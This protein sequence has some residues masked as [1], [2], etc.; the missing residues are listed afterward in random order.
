MSKKVLIF[1]PTEGVSHWAPTM[2]AQTKTYYGRNGKNNS[3]VS[4]IPS[5]ADIWKG[6]PREAK[7]FIRAH[8]PDIFGVSLYLWNEVFGHE[9]AKWVKEEF[10]DCLV[11]S[12]GPHQ[13]FKYT[14]DWYQKHPYIDVSLPGDSYG[15]DCMTKII[16]EEPYENIADIIWNDKGKIIKSPAGL[17]RNKFDYDWAPYTAQFD[18]IMQYWEYAYRYAPEKYVSFNFETTRGCP[19]GCTFC[20]WGGG[21]NAKVITKPD[22]AVKSDIDSICKQIN[23]TRSDIRFHNVFWSDANLGIMKER[24]VRLVEYFGQASEIIPREYK[25]NFLYGGM[26]KNDKVADYVEQ[27]ERIRYK[28]GLTGHNGTRERIDGYYKISVQSLDSLVLHNIERMNITF[29]RQVQTFNNLKKD[30]DMSAYAEMI[31][32]LPGATLD[33]YYEEYTKFFDVDIMPWYYEWVLLPEAPAYNPAYR[34]LHELKTVKTTCSW[35]SGDNYGKAYDVV[36]STSTMTTDDYLEIVS[37]IGLYK[38]FTQ[39][40]FMMD[41]INKLITQHNIGMGTFIRKFYKHWMTH[42]DYQII[43]KGI[44]ESWQEMVDTGHTDIGMTFDCPTSE[45]LIK[46]SLMRFFFVMLAD[47]FT[48]FTSCIPKWFESEFGFKC[49]PFDYMI[50]EGNEGTTR[51]VGI[52]KYDYTQNLDSILMEEFDKTRADASSTSLT[53]CLVDAIARNPKKYGASLIA[54]KSIF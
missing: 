49:K 10:P 30:Y 8:K 54:K 47:R 14:D 15:E 21:T 31:V 3:A 37:T 33:T 34:K 20:D 1:N 7:K 12:G 28:Y 46:L 19:Y 13:D 39:T 41:D 53:R 23:M 5:H 18:E 38:M 16:D 24:D 17:V 51:R 26:A 50:H 35:F 52:W 44:K 48:F 11:I 36:V 42:P 45:G 32:G 22:D 25:P 40:G 27:I 9:I 2:W 43:T 6:N 4:W 29:E